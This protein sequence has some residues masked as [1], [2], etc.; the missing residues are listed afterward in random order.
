M[1]TY[2]NW[3]TVYVR[4]LGSAG[5]KKTSPYNISSTRA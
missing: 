1:A 5:F 4:R 2:E 3:V